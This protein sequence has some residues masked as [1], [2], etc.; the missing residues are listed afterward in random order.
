MFPHLT[1]DDG[2]IVLEVNGAVDVRP[3]YS[4]ETDVYAAALGSL[5]RTADESLVL[6]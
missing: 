1:L 4:L 5:Q 3:L 6:A 2:W